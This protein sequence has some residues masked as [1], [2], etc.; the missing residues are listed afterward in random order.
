MLLRSILCSYHVYRISKIKIGQCSVFVVCE[1]KRV[2]NGEREIKIEREREEE[3]CLVDRT[4][5]IFYGCKNQITTIF[6]S[7]IQS[8]ANKYSSK[9]HETS[10]YT[11]DKTCILISINCYKLKKEKDKT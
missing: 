2:G 5:I 4:M 3:R 10:I 9:L 1:R 8:T 11:I 7:Y 6:L